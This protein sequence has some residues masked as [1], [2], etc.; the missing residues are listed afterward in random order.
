MRFR[1]PPVFCGWLLLVCLDP[2]K[3]KRCWGAQLLKAI[4][5]SESDGNALVWAHKETVC[6]PGPTKTQKMPSLPIL[7][8]A[9]ENQPDF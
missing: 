2:W 7:G 5:L 4:L 6:I 3:R 9:A 8:R 1:S